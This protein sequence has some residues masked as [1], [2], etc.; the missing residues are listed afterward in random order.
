MLYPMEDGVNTG[1][2]VEETVRHVRGTHSNNSD[3][4]H[5]KLG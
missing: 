5:G 2:Q 1:L 4:F 3:Q